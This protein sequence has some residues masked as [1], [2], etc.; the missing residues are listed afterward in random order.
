MEPAR[1]TAHLLALWLETPERLALHPS[2]VFLLGCSVERL[3]A[4]FHDPPHLLLGNKLAV[5]PLAWLDRH[6]L[7]QRPRRKAAKKVHARYFE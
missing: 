6:H 7:P 4:Q 3:T 1:L 5:E 2:T